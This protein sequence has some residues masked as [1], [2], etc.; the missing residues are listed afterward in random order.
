MKYDQFEKLLDDDLGWRKL[1]ISDLLL[2]A[3]ETQ[4]EIVYKS[5]ILL[6]YAHWEGFIKKS[7]KL[8]I[9]FISEEKIKVGELSHNFKAVALKE[10]VSKCIDSKDQMTLANEIT[11]VNS[12]VKIDDKRFKIDVRIDNDFDKTIIDTES[13]LKPKVF[14]NIMEILGLNYKKALEA[15]EHYI[16]SHLLANRNAI[17]HGSKFEADK[18]SDFALTLK[19]IE[20]LKAIV[21]SIID[22]YK[23]EL[24][25]YVYKKYY[26]ISNEQCRREFEEKKEEDLEKM[27]LSIEET[28]A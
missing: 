18:Q 21:F 24:L 11:F 1:E 19:D 28:F 7:S 13:N 20:K 4:K 15:R 10:K 23:E 14:K 9:K 2:L 3:K 25:E 5:L 27:F 6:L 16:N 12:F 22:N 8:Y 26:L 17:G